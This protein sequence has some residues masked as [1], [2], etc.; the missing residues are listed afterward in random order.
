MEIAI[1]WPHPNGLKETRGG[2]LVPLSKVDMEEL[3][4]IA[5]NVSKQSIF[6]FNGVGHPEY[7]QAVPG[8][9]GVCQF[10][11]VRALVRYRN[12]VKEVVFLFRKSRSKKK[13]YYREL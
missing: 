10:G 11:L 2:K 12:D 5:V 3:Q 4:E 13:I 8:K 6:V 7:I 9:V 1:T